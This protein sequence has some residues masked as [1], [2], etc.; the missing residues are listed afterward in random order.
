MGY[1]E[2]AT[3]LGRWQL[4]LSA[5]RHGVYSWLAQVARGSS[6]A[7]VRVVSEVRPQHTAVTVIQQFSQRSCHTR[8]PF[9]SEK[10]WE[11]PSG[12]AETNLWQASYCKNFGN[13]I[14][15]IQDTMPQEWGILNSWDPLA[16]DLLT[17]PRFADEMSPSHQSQ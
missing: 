4:N 13:S 17:H 15:A 10:R 9:E 1:F 14:L 6:A 7:T 3:S 16:V 2:R 11:A 8:R 5:G 12:Y